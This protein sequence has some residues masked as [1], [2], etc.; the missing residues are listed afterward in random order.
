[1]TY[2]DSFGVN[3]ACLRLTPG[4]S[5]VMLSPNRRAIY[6][7]CKYLLARARVDAGEGARCFPFRVRKLVGR[8]HS[9]RVS[10]PDYLRAVPEQLEGPHLR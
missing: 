6:L 2:F 4:S 1:M 7:S 9:R 3:D 10:C 8:I 5:P